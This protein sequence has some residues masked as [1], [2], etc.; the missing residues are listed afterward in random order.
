MARSTSP[1]YSLFKTH[2]LGQNLDENTSG[3]TLLELMVV[4]IIIGVLSAIAVPSWAGLTNTQKVARANDQALS[5]I[6]L[7][8]SR[9]MQQR[10]DYEVSFRMSGTQA[11]YALHPADVSPSDWENFPTEVKIDSETTLTTDSGNYR[12]IFDYQGYV[13]TG[14]R[15]L[16]FSSANGGST[17]R[18]V[19]VSTIIGTLRTSR[20]QATPKNGKYCY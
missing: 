8:Q 6:R 15:R 17:K 16:T 14:T 19:F 1:F 11:Q 12:I 5:A 10:L 4:V 9:A 2:I 7:A 20:E 13:S 3:F 18:C